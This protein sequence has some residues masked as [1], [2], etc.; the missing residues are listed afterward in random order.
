[1]IDERIAIVLK[2]EHNVVANLFQCIHWVLGVPL[3]QCAQ[4]AHVRE[5]LVL[6]RVAGVDE[7]FIVG[8]D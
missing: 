4:Q 7:R 8:Q 2:A 3:Q 6:P 5:R 1:M